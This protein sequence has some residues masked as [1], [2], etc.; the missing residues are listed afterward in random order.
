MTWITLGKRSRLMTCFVFDLSS[1]YC[2]KETVVPACT[3]MLTCCMDAWSRY[4]RQQRSASCILS[5]TVWKKRNVLTKNPG[6][7]LFISFCP[8]RES[9]HPPICCLC[10]F[11]ES[12]PCCFPEHDFLQTYLLL[13]LCRA[14]VV[15]LLAF[16]LRNSKVVQVFSGLWP[17][18]TC[19]FL[20]RFVAQV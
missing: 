11:E 8:M 16:P 20:C 1:L 5:R 7:C 9:L 10:L 14:T 13:W 4:A 12:S 19:T 17:A 3:L 2:G 6:L 15:C 18:C